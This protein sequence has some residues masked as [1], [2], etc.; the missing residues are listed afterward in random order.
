MREGHAMPLYFYV[1]DHHVF[2]DRL[3]PALTASWQTRSFACCQALCDL[4][5]AP[6]RAFRER[7]HIAAE[8]MMLPRIAR[9][10]PF[11]RRYWR[12]LVGEVLMVS[13]VE[14]PELETA[15]ESLAWIL[16]RRPSP[17]GRCDFSPIQQAHF[18]SRDLRFGA[19]YYRPEQAG[20]NDAD[21]VH[22]LSAY[23]TSLDPGHWTVADL[24]G[25]DSLTN[26]EERAEELE[27]VRDWLP[28]LVDLYR[29]AEACRHIVV[30]ETL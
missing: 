3:C 23:L 12:T 29:R 5:D 2:H 14:I 15:P 6:L 4:L 18:G 24:T 22:R 21:D 16:D 26:D 19:G 7:F 9:G 20:W 1:L 17:P 30:C 13:A 27:Y 25:L 8:D 11:D 28:A 10:L